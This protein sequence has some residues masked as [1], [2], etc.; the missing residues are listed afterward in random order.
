ML[1]MMPEPT[2]PTVMGFTD[3]ASASSFDWFSL[4]AVLS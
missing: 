3:I 4:V 2:T 1:L